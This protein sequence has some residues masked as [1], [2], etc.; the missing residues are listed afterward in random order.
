MAI[1]FLFLLGVANFA[2]HKA[3]LESGHAYRCFAT[4]EELEAM[5]EAQRAARQPMRYD[6][7]WRD[8]DPSEAPKDVKPVIRLKAPTEGETVVEDEVQGRVVWQ[9]KDLD[10]LVLLRSDG[11]PTYMLAVVVDDQ[12]GRAHV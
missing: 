2:M 5:R 4:S 6:G 11:T 7:R 9:N 12:I 1:L 8:R 10:D 3:V